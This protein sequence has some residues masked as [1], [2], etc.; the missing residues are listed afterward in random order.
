M[1]LFQNLCLLV[2]F[3]FGISALSAETIV[4]KRDKQNNLMEWKQDKSP[5]FQPLGEALAVESEN[6]AAIRLKSAGPPVVLI[7]QKAYT[8]KQGKV[9]KLSFS[10]SGNG[11]V[12]AGG[13]FYD[14]TWKYLGS[15]AKTFDVEKSE[16]KYEVMIHPNSPRIIQD[17]DFV[18]LVLSAAGWRSD[19]TIHDVS[20]ETVDPADIDFFEDTEQSAKQIPVS[21]I[22]SEK[23]LGAGLKNFTAVIPETHKGTSINAF[24]DRN[25]VCFNLKISK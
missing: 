4:F 22:S 3:I 20:V 17:P 18:T 15:C 10:V 5:Q 14:K 12:N 11:S 2:G 21:K 9:L 6:I 23:L 7:Y 19:I 8:L 13:Y 16:K 25:P 1:P 24:F